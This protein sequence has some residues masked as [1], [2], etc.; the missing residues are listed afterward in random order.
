MSVDEIAC[1][2]WS[3]NDGVYLRPPFLHPSEL[4]E[5][6][7]ARHGKRTAGADGGG[8]PSGDGGAAASKGAKGKNDN[9]WRQPKRQGAG[10]KQ[11]P[12]HHQGPARTPKI[13]NPACQAA[14]D[15][16]TSSLMASV[17]L[18]LDRWRYYL[19]DA[20]IVKGVVAKH[21]KAGSKKQDS[22]CRHLQGLSL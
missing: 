6:H 18:A 4:W 7:L 11:S 16:V 14:T 20:D 12:G 13:G 15:I 19:E 5:K 10:A 9:P 22:E 3:S 17:N 8:A 21:K 2:S 1:L